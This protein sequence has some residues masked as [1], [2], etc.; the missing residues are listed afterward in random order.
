MGISFLKVCEFTLKVILVLF[1]T[2]LNATGDIRRTLQAHI[3]VTA[4]CNVFISFSRLST[5]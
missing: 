3:A 4:N 5:R 1:A 2:F